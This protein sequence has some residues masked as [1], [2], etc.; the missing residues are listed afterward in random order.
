MWEIFSINISK[1]LEIEP[2]IMSS[3]VGVWPHVE[4]IHSI[5]DFLHKI[6]IS[7]FEK[8]TKLRLKTNLQFILLVLVNMLVAD[9]A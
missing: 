5:R 4:I 6:Q 2:L 9:R 1:L 7:T 8:T 3:C